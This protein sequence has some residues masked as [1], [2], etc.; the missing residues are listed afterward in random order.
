PRQGCDPHIFWGQGC[1]LPTELFPQK[2]FSIRKIRMRF[3]KRG[4]KVALFLLPTNKNK[5]FFEKCAN[6]SC[7]YSLRKCIA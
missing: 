7:F 5:D 3:A 1:A 4:A 6:P 2:S